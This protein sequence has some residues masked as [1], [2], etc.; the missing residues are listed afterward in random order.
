M[1]KIS[2]R[3]S[4]SANGVR[5]NPNGHRRGVNK[6]SPGMNGNNKLNNTNPASLRRSNGNFNALR[7]PANRSGTN[8][9]AK[10]ANG[11]P[12]R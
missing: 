2:L 11:N 3:T 7:S 9:P 6:S 5:S 12:S 10:I 1:P 8:N 4:A